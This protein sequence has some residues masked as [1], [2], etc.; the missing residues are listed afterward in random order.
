MNGLGKRSWSR[1]KPNECRVLLSKPAVVGTDMPKWLIPE[2]AN[3][4]KN[5]DL[6]PRCDGGRVVATWARDGH[7]TTICAHDNGRDRP[8]V[9]VRQATTV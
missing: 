6:V 5:D 1:L 9:E 7:K 8:G 3:A 4:N 2:L